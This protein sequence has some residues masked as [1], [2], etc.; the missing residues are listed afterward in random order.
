M[1]SPPIPTHSHLCPQVDVPVKYLSFFLD[2]DS[3]LEHIKTVSAM[4]LCCDDRSMG[5]EQ[6]GVRAARCKAVRHM[7]R[8]KYLSFFLDDDN[9]LEH[10]KTVSALSCVAVRAARCW[11][12]RHMSCAMKHLSLFLHGDGGDGS[13]GDDGGDGGDGDGESSWPRVFTSSSS[14]LLP[15]PLLQEYGAGRMLTGE[16]KGRL[17]EVLTG[18]VERHQKARALVTDEVGPSCRSTSAGH[19]ALLK[20]IRS[21]LVVCPPTHVSLFHLFPISSAPSHLSLPCTQ[22][23]DAFMAVRPMPH[24][25][26]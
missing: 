15:F 4:A 18:M 1:P 26:S 16:V 21:A 2:D 19:F 6:H 20:L 8:A 23:V 17:V 14:P 25:F 5:C 3:E 13:D 10:I 24:M 7:S 11:A 22:M 9:E 12:V